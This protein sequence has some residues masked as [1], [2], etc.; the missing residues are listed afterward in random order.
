MVSNQRLTV[1]ESVTLS[2]LKLAE[3]YKHVNDTQ[4]YKT[5]FKLKTIISNLSIISVIYS[6]V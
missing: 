2:Y 4:M 3:I 6:F 1:C 5:I